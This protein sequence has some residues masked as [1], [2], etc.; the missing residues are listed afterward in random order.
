MT[1]AGDAAGLRP[2][3]LAWLG[4]PCILF[5]ARF[6]EPMAGGPLLLLLLGAAVLVLRESLAPPAALRWAIAFAGALGL[7]AVAGFPQGPFA[8]D[9]IKHWALLDLLSQEHWPVVIDL[10]GQPA[11]LRFYVAAYLVPALAA[12][13]TG[14]TTALAVWFGAG[15]ML[16]L[17]GVSM[18]SPQR[19]GWIVLALLLFVGTAGADFVAQTVL[20]AAGGAPFAGLGAHA[21]NWFVN[22]SGLQLQLTSTL[23]ALVWVPHQAIAALLFV[24]LLLFD[25]GRHA[26]AGC[27]LAFGLLALWSP[28]GMIGALPLLAVRAWQERRALPWSVYPAAAGALGFGLL[29]AVY[30]SFES[31]VPASCLECLPLRLMSLQRYLPFWGVELAL[32]VL[33]LRRRIVSDPMCRTALGVVLVVTLLHG[34]TTDLVMRVTLAPLAVLALRTVQAL[35]PAAGGQGLGG[36]RGVG[37]V[38]LGLALTLPTAAS[39]A[40]YHV[41]HGAVHRALPVGDPLRETW[42][43][44]FAERSNYGIIEFFDRC[45]WRY[46][47]QYFSAHPPPMLRAP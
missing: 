20:R 12:S 11:H 33:V 3:I 6:V 15:Y 7:L 39:E 37:A 4:L 19:P 17:C 29:V 14:A 46:R 25:R 40:A 23:A 43:V 28:F 8:W 22:L 42:L 47:Q 44:T 36:A 30:L 18:V 31:P 26:L 10:K 16:A 21:E 41:G 9:W 45:G 13:S 24:V 35:L 32:F 27:V 38:A 2:W 5:L 34:E 1:G